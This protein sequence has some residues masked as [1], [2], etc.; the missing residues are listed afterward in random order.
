[1]LSD[2]YPELLPYW[3]PN[4]NLPQTPETTV[5]GSHKKVWWKCPE[6]GYEWEG[7]VRAR[8]GALSK[9]VCCGERHRPVAGN[10]LASKNPEVAKD[11]HPNN[12]IK[13]EDVSLG[14]H[15]MIN[16]I[17][18]RGHE[19][20]TSVRDRVKR[21]CKY[22]SGSFE[23]GTFKDLFPTI[24][25]EW[26]YEKNPMT[27]TPNN[28]S[29]FGDYNTEQF[30]WTC[31]A[32]KTGWDATPNQRIKGSGCPDCLQKKVINNPNAV[33]TFFE[34]D[35]SPFALEKYESIREMIDLVGQVHGRN[36]AF[37]SL[38][39]FGHELKMYRDAIG[40]DFENSVGIERNEQN[41]EMLKCLA[42]THF[43][44]MSIVNEDID[45]YALGL[46]QHPFHV[47]HLDYNGALV[48]AHLQAMAR[49]LVTGIHNVII[50]MTIVRN[51]RSKGIRYEAG[52]LPIIDEFANL[53]YFNSYKG[54][55]R[56]P[57]V[58]VYGYAMQ[59]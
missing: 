53:V 32:C 38:P 37:L 6:S 1:M 14:S 39:G 18:F 9:C 5:S 28:I 44:Q 23:K 47:V 33:K 29:P 25:D 49:L 12:G 42:A 57:M 13:P 21:G 4:K 17:C 41:V 8:V 56:T 11:W 59:K 26:D 51:P 55:A 54:R 15:K 43:G 46:S 35:V 40:L 27:V 3:H 20:R 30:Y 52:A 22:C 36:V 50:F 31:D 7:I 58:D 48:T 2:E 45:K 16:W 19:M 34:M 10:N 24:A